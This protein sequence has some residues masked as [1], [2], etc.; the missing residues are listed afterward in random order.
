[1]FQ[2]P[3]KSSINARAVPPVESGSR[4]QRV[5]FNASMLSCECRWPLGVKPFAVGVVTFAVAHSERR[6]AFAVT[7]SFNT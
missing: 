1:M 3:Q 7:G 4:A 6:S 5:G 2:P